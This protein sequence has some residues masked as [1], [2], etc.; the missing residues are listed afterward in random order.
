MVIYGRRRRAC[1][2]ETAVSNRTHLLL[3]IA[4]VFYRPVLT[5]HRTAPTFCLLWPRRV[6][7]VEVEVRVQLKA[8]GAT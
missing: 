2:L 5:R 6:L 8:T 1:W 3:F 7:L 4:L